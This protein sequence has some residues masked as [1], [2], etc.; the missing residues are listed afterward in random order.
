M[1]KSKK[2]IPSTKTIGSAIANKMIFPTNLN[3]VY[4]RFS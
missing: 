1:V 3:N 2:D 4:G